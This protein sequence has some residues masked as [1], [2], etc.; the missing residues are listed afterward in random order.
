MKTKTSHSE[1]G[2]LARG[3]PKTLT[4]TERKRRSNA[5][6]KVGLRNRRVMPV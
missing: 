5:M 2:K 1:R 3:V 6:R 4:V